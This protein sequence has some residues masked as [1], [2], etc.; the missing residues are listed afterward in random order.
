MIFYA[1]YKAFSAYFYHLSLILE[2][3]ILT[4]VRTIEEA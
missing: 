1:I 2:S 4:E 3:G